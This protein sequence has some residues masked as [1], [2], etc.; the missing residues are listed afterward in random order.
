[1]SRPNLNRWLWGVRI[2][3]ALLLVSCATG[4]RMANHGFTFSGHRDQWVDQVDLLAYSY[5]DRYRMVK[6][7]VENP[8]YPLKPGQTLPVG[9]SVHG[10][11]PVGEFL[12]VKWRIKSTGEVREDRVDLRPLLPSDMNDHSLT[13][14]IDGTQL[15]VY[16]VTPIP[17]KTDSPPILKT[18]KS[19]YTVTYEI[20]PTN[21][22]PHREQ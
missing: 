5:G 11:M 14:V 17:K 9:N 18:T 20:H 12:Y 1:M 6:D 8:R 19:R 21:T 2:A 3:L 22:Y 10:P 13:F 7:S 15:Y 4:A 16:L